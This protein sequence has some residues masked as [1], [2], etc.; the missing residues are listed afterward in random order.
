[1]GGASFPTYVKLS[2]P[3][4]KCI[5]T[6]IINGVECE[7]YLT[8]DHRLMLEEPD[9]IIL[10]MEIL[11]HALGVQD[12][13]IGIEVNKPDAIDLMEKKGCRVL[14]HGCIGK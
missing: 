4:D 3:P 6:L 8:A 14:L 12:Y 7:P 1:M 2:P 10:G 13:M 11:A 9:D 5:D